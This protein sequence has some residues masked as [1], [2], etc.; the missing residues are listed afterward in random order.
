HVV[1]IMLLMKI[2][3]IARA[4]GS[5]RNLTGLVRTY[6]SRIAV[7]KSIR[8]FNE[9]AV[10]IRDAR[11]TCAIAGRTRSRMDRPHPRGRLRRLCGVLSRVLWSGAGVRDSSAW[12]AGRGGGRRAGRLLRDLAASGELGRD[13]EARVVRFRRGAEPG[14]CPVSAS[15]GPR[16]GRGSPERD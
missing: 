9:S 6:I 5:L 10:T 13:V 1:K 2:R 4:A 14:D 3:S 15:A 11:P 12:L 7:A 8:A 16:Q